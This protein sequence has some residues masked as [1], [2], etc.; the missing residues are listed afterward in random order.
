MHH[1]DQGSWWIF[2]LQGFTGLS[3]TLAWF[4]LSSKNCCWLVNNTSQFAMWA[5][6]TN[7]QHTWLKCSDFIFSDVNN[8]LIKF[9]ILVVECGYVTSF[10][11]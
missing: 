10:N 2:I 8:K 11:I 1:L 6:K 5:T 4:T 9:V 3:Y 7:V